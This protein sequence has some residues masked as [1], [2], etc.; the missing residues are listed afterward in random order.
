MSIGPAPGIEPATLLSAVKCSTDWANP[1]IGHTFF[2]MLTKETT[3]L[4]ADSLHFCREI[5]LIFKV[6]SETA[7]NLSSIDAGSP[8]YSKMNCWTIWK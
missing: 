1:A 4:M 6:L 5:I 7:K 2:C 8:Q 3:P